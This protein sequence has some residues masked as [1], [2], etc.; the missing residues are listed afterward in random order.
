MA[1]VSMAVLAIR[2][3]PAVVLNLCC[4][5]LVTDDDDIA[6]LVDANGID[7]ADVGQRNQ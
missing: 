5:F 2:C 4:G 3:K 7:K 6:I 1:V